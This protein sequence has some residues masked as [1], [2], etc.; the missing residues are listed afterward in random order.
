M[1]SVSKNVYIDKLVDILGEYNNTYHIVDNKDNT[2]IDF[3]KEVNDKDTKFKVGGD[4][5]ISKY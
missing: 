3:R 5:R 4:V 1:T 2:Y